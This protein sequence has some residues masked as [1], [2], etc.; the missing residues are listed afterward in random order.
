METIFTGVATAV[1]TPFKKNYEIDYKALKNL[2]EFNVKNKVKAI[3]ICGTTGEAS[4]LTYEERNSVIKFSAEVVG[5]RVPLVAGVGSNNFQSTIKMMK[6]VEKFVDA[7]LIVTPYYNKTTQEGLKKI[8]SLYAKNTFKPIIAYNV[9]GR[10]G[11]NMLPQTYKSLSGK[12]YGVKEASSDI[13]QLSSSIV[14]CPKLTFYT[15][16]DDLILPSLSLGAKGVISV[17]SNIIPSEI[18]SMIEHYFKGKVN[19]ATKEQIKYMPLIK[20]MFCEV[21]PIPVKYALYKMGL[22][23]NVLRLPLVELSKE[24]QI[25]TDKILKR[26]SLI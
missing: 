8:Y 10:T 1:V 3:V 19:V 5:G 21:N 16:N 4:T 6:D 25:V 13:S 15:G 18:Q 20:Q 22:I 11:L 17:V 2:I 9:P 26:Y 7:F 12:I 14:L 23:K 24:N